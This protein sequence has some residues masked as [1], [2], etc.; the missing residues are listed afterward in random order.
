MGAALLR[1]EA[2]I[3]AGLL[4]L[5]PISALGDK[6]SAYDAEHVLLIKRM[7]A[8]GQ[9]IHPGIKKRLGM[10]TGYTD[11]AGGVL[12]IAD[13]EIALAPG[14]ADSIPLRMAAQERAIVEVRLR[15]AV[16]G[17]DIDLTVKAN[18]TV[19]GTDHGPLTGREDTGLFFQFVPEECIDID[20]VVTNVG[21]VPVM[22]VLLAPASVQ[23]GCS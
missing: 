18:G 23:V 21:P 16:A 10:C 2:L 7:I 14:E 17:A 20:V 19:V 6:V 13:A 8:K 4:G 3:M 15:Q 12:C 1:I 11:P 5:F 9:A 22:A